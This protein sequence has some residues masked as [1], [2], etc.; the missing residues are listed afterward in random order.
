[1][2]KKKIKLLCVCM[3]LFSI[4][5][6]QQDYMITQY[7]FN[8]LFINP[9]YTGVH[10]YF[11]TSLLHRNQWTGFTDG[12]P[13][14]TLFAI[15][16]PVFKNSTGLG[17][18]LGDDRLGVTQQNDIMANYSY[19]LKFKKSALSFG[20][21]SGFSFYKANVNDLVYWDSNDP[22]YINYKNRVTPK[23]GTGIFYHSDK[24]YVG[25][26]IPT[27]I[28]HENGNG[29]DW[30][31]E[32]GT[33]LRRHY[34]LTGGYVFENGELWKFKPSFLLKYTSTA[35]LEA[36]INFSVL[37]KEMLSLGASYRTN[38]A[39]VAIFQ[40]QANQRF[41]VG[42]SYDFTISDL[43]NYTT[44]SHEIMLGFDLGKD[45]IKMKSSRYFYY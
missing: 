23:F 13:R 38:D 33:F 2:K 22:V 43:R 18:I 11:T 34:F 5:R 14:T 12:A 10:K 31:F 3:L 8:G 7:M 19:Q 4:V 21:R 32:K 35:P 9:A 24:Y 1:M 44:G 39:I 37:Y 36:D 29:F 16:G 45:V 25:L 27:L 20:L 28:A 6:A 15:D 30:D 17:L 40:Y 41:R 42:Y 26:S